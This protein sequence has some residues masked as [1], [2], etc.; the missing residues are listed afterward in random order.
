MAMVVLPR[1]LAYRPNRWVN[2]LVGALMTVVQAATLFV[3]TP[4]LYYVFFS[5]I[6][7]ATTG[8]IVW[9]A[10]AWRDLG[11][12]TVPGPVVAPTA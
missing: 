12:G 7:I 5:A 2:I 10:W 3:G 8:F 4:T 6:E 9:S 11:A 1:L